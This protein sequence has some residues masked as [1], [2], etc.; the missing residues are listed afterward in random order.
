MSKNLCLVLAIV[1]ASGGM[2]SCSKEKTA[3]QI[4]M[5]QE[6]AWRADKR[7]RAIKFYRD[8][9]TKYPDSPYAAQA[10]ERLAA[11][12]TTV[13]PPSAGGPAKPN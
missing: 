6:A 5:E 7:E 4:H 3:A 1:L 11:L 8:L 12:G 2:V 10:K 13:Q 9:A